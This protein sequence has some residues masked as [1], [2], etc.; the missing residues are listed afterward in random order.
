MVTLLKVIQDSR[1]AVESKVDGVCMHLS[2]VHQDLRRMADRV[3]ETETRV[4]TAEDT[5]TTLQ[6]R[7]S[8]LT[9]KVTG[10]EERAEDAKNR[11]RRKS[12]W[13]GIFDYTLLLADWCAGQQAQRPTWRLNAWYLKSPECAKFVEEKLEAFFCY[14]EGSVDSK[15]MLWAASKPAMCGI[16]KSSSGD[17]RKPEGEMCSAR[18]QATRVGG[19][20]W[21]LR[22]TGGAA[23]TGPGAV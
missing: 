19:P 7:V 1:E 5:L 15:A 9:S 16:I 13:R 2:L 4:S 14:N 23:S 6:T 21:A 12:S 8:Q 20:D 18:G 3:T 17:R 22:Y 10:L 11:S